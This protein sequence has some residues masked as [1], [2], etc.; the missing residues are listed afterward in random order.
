MYFTLKQREN[1]RFHVASTWNTRDVLVGKPAINKI[2]FYTSNNVPKVGSNKRL[3]DKVN[4]WFSAELWAGKLQELTYLM[5]LKIFFF[6]TGIF[7]M[8]L[9]YRRL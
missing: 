5:G 8:R 4:Y 7:S 3:K 9:I 2:S 1:S 6:N